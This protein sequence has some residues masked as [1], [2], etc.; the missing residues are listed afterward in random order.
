MKDP[1]RELRAYRNAS[2]AL[3]RKAKRHSIPCHLCRKP[4]DWDLPYYDGMAFTADHLDPLDNGGAILGTLLPA[5]RS[6]NSKKGNG[7]RER[8]LPTTRA[9]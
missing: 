5:H 8:R 2:Q 9:W 1:R 3:K 4:F 7:A 6:C